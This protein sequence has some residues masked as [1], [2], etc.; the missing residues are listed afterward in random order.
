MAEQRGY[1][2]VSIHHVA[3]KQGNTNVWLEGS[4]KKV[5]CELFVAFFFE[6]LQI[7]GVNYFVVRHLRWAK[8][9]CSNIMAL[10][11]SLVNSDQ[12]QAKT[13]RHRILF[14]GHFYLP[15]GSDF[16]HI[17]KRKKSTIAITCPEQYVQLSKTAK[18]KIPHCAILIFPN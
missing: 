16:S 8:P 3:C 11:L 17:E 7:M 18:K 5:S 12:I 14:S 2:N 6:A 1:Y 10:L 13:I 15:K 9:Q 4:A